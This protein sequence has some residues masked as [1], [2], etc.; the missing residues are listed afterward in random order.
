MQELNLPSRGQNPMP[1]RLA[2]PL[3]QAAV[4]RLVDIALDGFH[5]G[6]D[7]PIPVLRSHTLF[8]A[9]PYGE[10]GEGGWGCPS[11][12]YLQNCGHT[13]PGGCILTHQPSRRGHNILCCML[14][15]LHDC[16]CN[17]RNHCAP[18]DC[19]FRQLSIIIILLSCYALSRRKHEFLYRLR[20]P[21]PGGLYSLHMPSV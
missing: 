21:A 8:S 10:G 19:G 18:M 15:I 16:L 1:C 9:T 12:L 7:T 13:R 20:C 14:C 5:A 3:Y 6:V 4:I 11:P 2:Y 17:P